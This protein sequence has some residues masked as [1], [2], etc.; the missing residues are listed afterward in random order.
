[1][2]S[3]YGS[4]AKSQQP[5]SCSDSSAKSFPPSIFKGEAQNTSWMKP[6]SLPIEGMAIRPT[7]HLE[8]PSSASPFHLARTNCFPRLSEPRF[9][10]SNQD[11]FVL[12]TH[13]SPRERV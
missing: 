8:G 2:Q 1:M 6:D 5:T 11:W 7:A 3:S 13:P 12:S 10:S 4:R 9:H